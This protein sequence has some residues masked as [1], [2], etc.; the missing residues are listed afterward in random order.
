MDRGTLPIFRLAGI[1]VRLHFTWFI[2]FFLIAWSL[3]QGIFPLQ[4]PGWP[5]STYWVLGSTTALLLFGSVLFHEFAHS[6][7]AL[8][9][10]LKVD[11]ITLFVFGG[12][13]ALKSEPRT[14]GDEFLISIVGPASSLLLAAFFWLLGVAIPDSV[15]AHALVAYLGLI[16]ASL[17][18]FNLLPGLPLDGGRVF[19]ALIWALTGSMS[20]GTTVAT[21]VG[22][23]FAFGF[24][25]LGVF[26]LF[27]GSFFAGVWTIFIG[28]FMN[29]AATSSRRQVSFDETLREIPASSLM[30][31]DPAVVQPANSLDRVVLT[32]L[33]RDGVRALP[34]MQDG[35]VVG[36]IT[37]NDVRAVPQHT[38]SYRTVAS[39]M[40]P[41]P[42][43]SVSPDD[44]VLRVMQLMEES[45]VQQMLVMK[46]DTVVGL[47]N[48]Q[49]IVRFLQLSRELGGKAKLGRRGR[50]EGPVERPAG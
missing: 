34:V 50:A 44:S 15:P 28:W 23:F 25:A 11:S 10:G 20:K 33:L 6:F 21:F 13:A 32:M 27:S 4:N 8:A 46:G 16:N 42:L 1:E 45:A 40:T 37:V 49:D 29:G 7:M 17:A 26:L 18:L 9:R 39:A 31:S 43:A 30:R 48:R 41:S 2:A 19:R 12:A 3:A 47:L 36:I 14:P 5:D 24:I 38:W 22:Q 35:R